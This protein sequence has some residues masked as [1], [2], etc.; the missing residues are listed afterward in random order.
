ME[1]ESKFKDAISKLTSKVDKMHGKIT[2]DLKTELKNL[3]EHNVADLLDDAIAKYETYRPC[4]KARLSE[5]DTSTVDSL[6][7]KIDIIISQYQAMNQELQE[8]R[9]SQQQINTKIEIQNKKIVE[10]EMKMEAASLENRKMKEKI[11][12]T[13]HL[14]DEIDQTQR[15]DSL[16]INGLPEKERENLKKEIENLVSALGQEIYDQDIRTAFR[17][18][19]YSRADSIRLPQPSIVMVK[20]NN[21]HIRSLLLKRR[22]ELKNATGHKLYVHENLT[23]HR[24]RLFAKARDDSKRKGYKHCWTTNGKI[25]VKK[26]DFSTAIPISSYDSLQ[27]ITDTNEE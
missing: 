19:K 12:A 14:L 18:P 22:R 24:R 17:L 5:A 27:K 1:M 11:L 20:F 25:Y 16:E 21:L 7:E 6:H 4:N 15:G 2:K 8:I 9:N 26:E 3:V 23:K 13:D 10:L